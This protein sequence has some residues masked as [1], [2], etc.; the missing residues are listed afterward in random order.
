MIR[1][2]QPVWHRKT[3]QKGMVITVYKRNAVQVHTSQGR[4]NWKV[5][6]YRRG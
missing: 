1:L 3:G 6:E 4:Q 5:G 2:G